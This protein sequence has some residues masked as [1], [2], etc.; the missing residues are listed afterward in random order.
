LINAPLLLSMIC[1]SVGGSLRA[2]DF[3]KFY[4]RVVM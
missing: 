1:L 3:L 4:K 2:T